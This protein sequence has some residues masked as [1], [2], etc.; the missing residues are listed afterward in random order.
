[1][2][3]F[4][5]GRLGCILCDAPRETY[6]HIFVECPFIKA[7]AYVCRWALKWDKE[8]CGTIEDVVF[9]CLCGDGNAF[10]S[11]L[12][13]MEATMVLV[14]LVEVVWAARNTKVHDGRVDVL[15]VVRN[16]ELRV[17]EFTLSRKRTTEKRKVS[18]PIYGQDQQRDGLW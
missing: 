8:H 16:L 9:C 15:E 17:D 1:M 10:G 4:T 7:V 5:I 14:F 12:G 6:V 18:A 11:M 3:N 13:K 2:E